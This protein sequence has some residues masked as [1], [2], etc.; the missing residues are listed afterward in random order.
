[1]RLSD[2]KKLLLRA[3]AFNIL[4]HPQFAD[5]TRFLSS[6]LFGISPSSLDLMLGSGSPISG[7]APAFQSGGPRS[8]QLSLRFSF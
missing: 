4:N 6:P 3:E 5:P 7:K 1:L 2:T 8:I